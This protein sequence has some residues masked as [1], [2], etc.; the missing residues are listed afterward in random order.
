M[1]WQLLHT[2]VTAA[3][4]G[5]EKATTRAAAASTTVNVIIDL[6]IFSPSPLVSSLPFYN[7][8][9]VLLSYY[10]PCLLLNKHFCIKFKHIMCQ[11]Q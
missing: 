4:A 10:R 2:P 6:F 8:V 3:D 9:V 5:P 7:F 11:K 1:V